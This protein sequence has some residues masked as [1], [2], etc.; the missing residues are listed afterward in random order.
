MYF[1]QPMNGTPVTH[2]T[3]NDRIRSFSIFLFVQ[4]LSHV[5]PMDCNNPG[6]P[7]IHISQSLLKLLSF[8][9]LMPPKHL[10]L[11]HSLLFLLS[12]FPS[13][14][15]FSNELALRMRWPK[16]WSFNFSISPPNVYSRLISLELTY[17][18]SLLSKGL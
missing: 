18:I 2:I 15:V 17:L 16:H 5:D 3:E 9:S 7:V 12:I 11:S 10:K 14:R 1:F 8:E 4:S 13:I 6:F